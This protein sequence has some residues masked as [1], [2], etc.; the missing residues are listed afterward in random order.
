MPDARLCLHSN[1][2]GPAP[3]SW[4]L[5]LTDEIN[6][7][8]TNAG[9]CRDGAHGPGTCSRCR[10]LSGELSRL[11][12]RKRVWLLARAADPLGRADTYWCSGLPLELL[13]ISKESL[14]MG[15]ETNKRPGVDA[16]WRLLFAFP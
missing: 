8:S 7:P 14:S 13:A 11:W 9:G 10:R 15:P 3:L 6:N 4:M 2:L 5:V 12:I 1:A 16:G